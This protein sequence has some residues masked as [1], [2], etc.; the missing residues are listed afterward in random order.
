MS[1]RLIQAVY[2]ASALL[3]ILGLKRLSKVKTARGG[4][5]IAALAMLLAVAATLVLLWGDIGIGLVVAGI[6]IGSAVGA[7]L[8]R[9]VPMTSMPELVAL[10]NGLGGGASMF[11]AWAEVARFVGAREGESALGSVAQGLRRES[12]FLGGTDFTVAALLSVLIGAV[13]LSGC[14]QMTSAIPVP[15]RTPIPL[16]STSSPIH[17]LLQQW[18]IQ[19]PPRQM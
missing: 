18:T 3:F 2:M 10:F 11:V 12:V 9:R 17:L 14:M 15:T 16:P 8:A 19:Q 7:I 5:R 13:T 1:E 4:S 6:V